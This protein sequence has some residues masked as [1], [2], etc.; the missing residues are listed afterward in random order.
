MKLW[1]VPSAAVRQAPHVRWWCTDLWA[2]YKEGPVGLTAT[3]TP[4]LNSKPGFSQSGR[5]TVC[6]SFIII[7]QREIEKVT[8]SNISLL[9]RISQLKCWEHIR[10]MSKTIK[11]NQNQNCFNLSDLVWRLLNVHAWF[12]DTFIIV[13]PSAAG[14]TNQQL[15]LCS[16]FTNEP[17][18]DPLRPISGTTATVRPVTA[19]RGVRVSAVKIS[20]LW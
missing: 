10:K 11:T 12:N 14:P 18:N 4:W 13:W 6:Q 9:S 20:A 5:K 1:L 17:W 2:S 16:R 8:S 19:R 15:N 7:D 3:A